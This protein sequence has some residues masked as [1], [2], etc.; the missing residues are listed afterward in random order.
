MHHSFTTSEKKTVSD[1][2]D[3]LRDRKLL[4]VRV[5][6]DGGGEVWLG[7]V[8]SVRAQPTGHTITMDF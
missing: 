1:A 3:A 6:M 2:I 8:V 7:K 4:N 5:P